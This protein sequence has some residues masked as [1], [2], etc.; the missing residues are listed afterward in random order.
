MK[1]NNVKIGFR[2]WLLLKLSKLNNYISLYLKNKSKEIKNTKLNIKRENSLKLYKSLLKTRKHLEGVKIK[3]VIR[4]K[5]IQIPVVNTFG[6]I[7]PCNA[8]IK[9]YLEKFLP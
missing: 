1:I 4:D 5:K 6:M 9:D 7:E 3:D 2:L 8:E